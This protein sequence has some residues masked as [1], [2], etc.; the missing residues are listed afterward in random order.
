MT[1]Q[2]I[3][4]SLLDFIRPYLPAFASEID[5]FHALRLIVIVFG[6]YVLRNAVSKYLTNK[7]LQD[8]LNKD[9]SERDEQKIQ[10]LVDDPSVKGDSTGLDDGSWGFGKKTRRVVK[11]QQK[12]FQEQ[13]ERMQAGE[14]SDDDI[15][16]LLED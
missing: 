16:D 12:I 5:P 2:N 3:A 8:Q 10:E 6:Y 15:A 14:D 9:A 7:Q 11:H 1:N 13:L 4:V